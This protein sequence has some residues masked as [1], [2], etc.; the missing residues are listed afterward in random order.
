MPLTL[1]CRGALYVPSKEKAFFQYYSDRWN[2]ILS[3]NKFK[4]RLNVNMDLD[5][6]EGMFHA[7]G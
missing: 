7:C 2:E 5:F 3:K 4:V 6:G 1:K